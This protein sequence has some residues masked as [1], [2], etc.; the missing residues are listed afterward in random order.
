MVKLELLTVLVWIWRWQSHV[1]F[2]PKENVRSRHLQNVKMIFGNGSANLANCGAELFI[3]IA[4][5]FQ[6]G[7]QQD[8]NNKGNALAYS[9][10]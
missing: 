2:S 1:N 9:P 8:S 7:E 4:K 6:D 5:A 3:I 10:R